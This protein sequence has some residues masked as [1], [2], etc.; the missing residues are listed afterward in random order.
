MKVTY[1]FKN[2]LNKQSKI[3]QD[4]KITKIIRIVIVPGL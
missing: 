1:D 2:S 4:W 3:L